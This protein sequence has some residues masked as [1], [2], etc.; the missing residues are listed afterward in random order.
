MTL[1]TQVLLEALAQGLIF[2]CL[3]ISVF[4]TAR[5]VKLDDLSI[6]GSFGMGGAV[7]AAALSHGQNPCLTLLFALAAGAVVGGITGWLHTKKH[8]NHLIAGVATATAAYSVNLFVA[9]ANVSLLGTKTIFDGARL[10]CPHGDLV[11][12]SAIF[13]GMV[14]GVRWLLGTELGYWLRASG[15]NPLLVTSLGKPVALY[16]T[17]V[18]CLAGA[19]A[20]LSG[21]LFVQF[22]GFFSIT[23]SMGTMILGLTGLILSETLSHRLGIATLLGSVTCQLLFA[24]IIVMGWSPSWNYFFK[25]ALIVCCLSL[26][27]QRKPQGTLC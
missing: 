5:V 20:G 15:S 13:A 23:G 17:S 24:L 6:E 7:V 18:F 26:N 3:T 9:G 21:G 10:F 12:L 27:P 19:A 8:I 1:L 25:A 22:V 2:G 14:I 16:Q 4:L 11:V